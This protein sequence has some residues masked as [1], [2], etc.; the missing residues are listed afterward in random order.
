MMPTT[1]TRP[2]GPRG[3]AM[4]MVLVAVLIL[5]LVLLEFSKTSRTHLNQ[6]VN[7]RD[8][9]RANVIAE[10]GMVLTR[11]CLDPSIWG[12]MAGQM[13]KMDMQKVCNLLLG[14]FLAG[15]VDLPVGGLSV[16]LEG[17]DNLGIGKGGLEEMELV[18]EESFIGLAGMYCPN[19]QQT[20]APDLN[21]TSRIQTAGKLRSILC[22]PDIAHVFENEQ[23]DGKRYTRWD[24][25]TNIADWMDRDD[26]RMQFD[27]LTGQFIQGAGEGED[28]YYGD[29]DDRYRAKDAP[30]DSIEELRLIRGI[31]DDLFNFLKDRVSVH[32]REKVNVQTASR[33][34]FEALLR[35]NAPAFQVIENNSC[36]EETS[37]TPQDQMDQALTMYADLIVKARDDY[38]FQRMMSGN[39]FGNTF[40]NNQDFLRI[41]QDPLASLMNGQ[42]AQFNPAMMQQYLALSQDPTYAILRGQVINWQ[43]LAQGVTVRVAERMF[44]LNIKARVG[45]ISRRV[46]AVLKQDGPV[47]R[48]LYYR[49]D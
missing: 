9:V 1:H 8:T 49:E 18:P 11:A 10:T 5:T 28:S 40:R 19:N 21:C 32:A 7:V 2:R 4:V 14:V 17:I 20:G 43:Q 27:P 42:M 25:I 23:E 34:I 39:F 29:S 6:G 3:V 12:P 30:L 22:D 36:G 41:A 37:G 45:N 35:A 16:E 13:A 15:R 24:I 46:M 48:T 33:D 31:N 47:V 38:A 26:N 44:R